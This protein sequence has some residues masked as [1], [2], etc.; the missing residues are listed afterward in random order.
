M[1]CDSDEA[2][3]VSS[4]CESASIEKH[5]GNVD[6]A[7]E[8]WNCVSA[9]SVSSVSEVTREEIEGQIVSVG[10]LRGEPLTEFSSAEMQVRIL[11]HVYLW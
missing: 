7:R 9:G 8:L 5:Q 11:K 10:I 1:N 4:V 2:Q 6:W 3:A